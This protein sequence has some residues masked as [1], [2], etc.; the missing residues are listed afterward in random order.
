MTEEQII[1]LILETI[2]C[3]LVILGYLIKYKRKIQLIAGVCKNDDQIKDKRGFASL[4]G[5]NVLLSGVIFCTGAIGIYFYPN[6]KNI[7]EPV[8]LLSLLAT[9]ILT[10][11]KSKKYIKR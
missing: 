10:Y 7:I 8:L 5:G 2:G 9:I 4:V 3:L 6:F 11:T 1:F